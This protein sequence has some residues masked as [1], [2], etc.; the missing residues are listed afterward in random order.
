MR[1][2]ARPVFYNESGHRARV[3]NGALLLIS[4]LAALGLL[5][6]VYGML[7]APNLPVAERQA[8]DATAPHAEMINRRVVVADPIN[9]ALNRQ[10]P[11]AAMQALRLAYLSSNGNAFT[12]LKQHAGDLD[13]LLPDWLELRQEDG[14][15]RIQVDGKS[16]EVLQWLKTNAQQLQVFPVIS[17]SLTKHETNVALALPAARARVIAEIIGYLQEN[18]LSGITLQLPD[19]TPFNERILVQFVRDLRERLSA[20]QRKLIVMTSL[21][22]G[23]VRIGEFSKVADYVLVAT[24]DN[25]QAGRPAPIA[26]QGWLESQLGSVFARVDPGKVIVSIG[27]LAFDWDPTGRMKQISVPAAWT[28]MRNNGKSLAFDQRS[29]NATVR[30]RDGDGRP[31]EIWMLDA[32]TGFNHLR[33]ALA[34]R[35]AGVA[36]WALGYEDAGIWATLGRTKLPD[37]TALGALETLQP[38]GD[39]F[40]SL[41]VALVSATPGGAGRR[42]LAYNERVGLIVGQA[43]AQAPSQAQVITRSPVAKNLVALTFD[44]GPDPNYT[45]RVLDILRE[46][47]AKATFY[48]VGR[49]ALQAPGLLKR[50]YDEGHDI[51]N[52]TFSHPRLM[53]SGRERIAVELNMAQRVIEA[54]TGV[55][56]TLFRPP[57]AY[58]SLAFLDTSPL[59]VEVATELGYQIG[60]LDADSYD[61]AAA[62]FGGV[63]KIHVVDLVVRTVG[64]GRGQIVLM[65]DSGGNRQLTIDA[66]PD[67][68]DQLHAKGFRFVTTHEL[69]GAPRDA[70][71]PQTRAPSLTDAL[72]TEAWRVGAHSAAWLSDAVPAIA[73]ATSVLA[74]FRLTLIIIGATAHRL[75]GG[76]RIPAA[77]PEPKGIAVLVPAYN[78]EIV[79]LKTI[80]TLLGSTVADRIE[81]IVI[82][83]GSTDETASVV[84]EAFGTTGAVQIFTK[85][86]GGKAAALNFGLQ[87]TSAEIIVAIDGDT[88]LLPDAIERLARHFADPRI[89]AVA[90]TV[91][92]GNRTSLIARFQALEYTLSQN[93][94]RRAF[95]LIN[96]IGV[97]PGAIGAWRREALLA[98][99]GYSSDTLAEDAD[100]TVS[101]ELAGWKVVCEPRAR[102][103]TEAPERLG[104]FLKQRFRWMFGTLQVAYKHGAASLRRPRGVSF[105]LVPNVLL[106]QFLFTLLAPLMDLI[107]LFTVV[108][109]VIDIV[110]AG[111]RGQGHETLELLAAYWLV[112][113]VFDLLA[114]C[115]ALLLHGPSTEWRLLPLLVLQ[116]FCYRQLLY[117]TAIRTLLTALRGT[118]VGWG[119]LVR[120]GSVDLP[121]APARSA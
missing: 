2:E 81:I 6:L 64:G 108:T 65:H 57:Q 74:I 110:T 27:S 56:T 30:Y 55:R 91:S 71:M 17:S 63:K 11:A 92:V 117:V 80:R 58:T 48:I 78:E 106:F 102:A 86:N 103:L 19:A 35:P 1:P 93:L 26:P 94:D 7:V 32:V 68:I 107:L 16:A 69:V 72:S 3:T 36:L 85:A 38:G 15:I 66:L 121:V 119:K 41:N 50:I 23:P 44:D 5:A 83:D 82:D 113:Q 9:P 25:V 109:S 40:G 61:W 84:R 87:K 52:H 76:H 62:G 29:L 34:H 120:T 75:R 88:V 13:G 95:E 89:G 118:F 10:V 53:E 51:G 24:H 101:L 20:T 104:A 54:Q 115:A 43:I 79:I 45:G 59:L 49:N 73:I 98:V 46:K 111:A 8:S 77:G 99:G 4:C 14:R 90:G 67:I 116:R 18:E 28:A 47:G 105:V 114:G 70:V 33:A 96:A 21:T 12:S 22:D 42:T 60:A 97:V 112:F 39:L 100:L 31:H 37:S